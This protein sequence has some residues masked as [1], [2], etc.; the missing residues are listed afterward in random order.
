MT[1]TLIPLLSRGG[2]GSK[3]AH[4]GFA[5]RAVV[6]KSC[7]FGPLGQNKAAITID[8]SAYAKLIS[9]QTQLSLRKGSGMIRP[10][11]T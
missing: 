1:V 11:L 2:R 4:A 9:S 5:S 10:E 6:S 7:M 3:N 8:I